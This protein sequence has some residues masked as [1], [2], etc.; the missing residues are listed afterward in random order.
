MKVTVL[1]KELGTADSF[2]YVDDEQIQFAGFSPNGAAG[3][4]LIAQAKTTLP[5]EYDLS[6][7]LTTGTCQVSWI[8]VN[9]P[10]E[11]DEEGETTEEQQSQ[12]FHPDWTRVFSA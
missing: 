11:D 8:E 3:K 12:D 10:E 6:I 7:N 1:G 5:D 4:A 2:D 9:E